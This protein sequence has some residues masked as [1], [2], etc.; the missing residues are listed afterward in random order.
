MKSPDFSKALSDKN[1]ERA[2]LGSAFLGLGSFALPVVAP[3]ALA[4][5]ISSQAIFWT[6]QMTKDTD[7]T[8]E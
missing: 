5:M 8:E 3:I 2:F 6:K 1:L 7:V 4:G